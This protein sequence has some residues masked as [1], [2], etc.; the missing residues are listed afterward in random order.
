MSD[1][2]QVLGA[3]Y[4]AMQWPLVQGRTAMIVID[5]QNDFLH[6]DGWYATHGIDISHMRRSII[7]TAK[8][9]AAAHERRIPV[10]WTQHGFKDA[11]DAASSSRCARCS[12]KAVF[13]LAVGVMLFL[14]GWAPRT[15]TGLY[16][17]AG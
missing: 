17:R 1:N 11:S 3:A 7:P 10:I 12:P 9:V 8:L 5:A 2:E 14:M 6:T 13:A 4:P 15:M 16:T